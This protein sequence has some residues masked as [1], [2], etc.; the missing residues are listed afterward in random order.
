MQLTNRT[1]WPMHAGIRPQLRARHP[2][3]R[4]NEMA[5]DVVGWLME[6]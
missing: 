6:P 5:A 1:A 3:A 4:L 2:A